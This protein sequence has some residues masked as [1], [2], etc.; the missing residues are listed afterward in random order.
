[1]NYWSEMSVKFANQRN[2]LDMLFRV[3]PISPNLRREISDKKWH[4]IEEAFIK[5][6]NAN[7]VKSLLKLELFPIKDS[8]VSYL[9]RDPSSFER[10]PETVNRIAGNL[11]EIGLDKIYEK[12]TEPKE[13]NRQI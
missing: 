10:N 1:M 4:D 9:K 7:L 3:Y 2:Y 8:Y 11:F 13:T 12:C 6:E 5:H